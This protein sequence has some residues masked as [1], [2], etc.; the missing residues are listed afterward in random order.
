MPFRALTVID[1]AT[2]GAAPQIASFFGDLGARVIKVEHPRGD[3]LRQLID[4]RGDALQWRII[5]RTKECVTL[6][7]SR[8][9]GRE[10]LGRLLARADLLVSN[11]SAERLQRWG[12]RENDLHARHPRLVT[13]NLTAYG[14]SGPWSERP[15]S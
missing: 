8:P 2:L 10:I 4:E 11:L 7:V 3:G 12:L 6:D 5:N 15:G 13:V 14:L 1:L 9:E